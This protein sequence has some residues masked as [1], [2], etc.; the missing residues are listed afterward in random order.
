MLAASVDSHHLAQYLQD[1]I[2]AGG[3][4]DLLEE[5]VQSKDAGKTAADLLPDVLLRVYRQERLLSLQDL[6]GNERLKEG[7][8]VLLLRQPAN[9]H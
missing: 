8:M 3:R 7:D 5:R 6:Q 2:T 4:I 1:L 9:H